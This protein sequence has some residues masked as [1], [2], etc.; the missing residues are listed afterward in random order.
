MI[1]EVG[2]NFFETRKNGSLIKILKNDTGIGT[3]QMSGIEGII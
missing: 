3:V 1:F 2:D